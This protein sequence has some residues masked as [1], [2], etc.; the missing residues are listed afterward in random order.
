MIILLLF[1]IILIII[2]Y[3]LESPLKSFSKQ[4]LNENS[5]I[6]VIKKDQQKYFDTFKYFL[7]SS[8]CKQTKFPIYLNS[9]PSD[10]SKF[11]FFNTEQLTRK[12]YLKFVKEVSNS[13]PVEMWDYS[14]ANI[15][16]LKDSGINSV[17]VPLIS[18]K[19][20]ID[21]I[22]FWKTNEFDVGFC[23]HLSPKRKFII[24]D[25]KSKGLKVMCTNNEF[26]DARDKK[27]AK[28]KIILNIHYNDEYL[29]FEQCR[30]EPW[31]QAGY[32][33]VSENSLD[34]DD[35]IINVP[36]ENLVN[37]CLKIIGNN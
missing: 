10:D 26:G 24:N 37:T 34:N 13:N 15:K 17:H 30:C 11:I 18:P 32:I 2:K 8:N 33:I 7:Q 31:I 6:V 20:Y 19:W 4:S 14:L 29:I 21:R 25:L 36:Y 27:L 28:C 5:N 23:G 12:H 35:R 16:I 1:F 22:L 3:K 9:V